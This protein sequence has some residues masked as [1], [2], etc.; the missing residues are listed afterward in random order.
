M[1]ERILRLIIKEFIQVLRDPRMKAMIFVLPIIQLLIF[2]YAVTTDVNNIKTIL[3]DSDKSVQSRQL[4]ESF[5]SS[6]LFTIVAYSEN[7]S[8]ITKSLDRG[9]AVI[10]VNIKKGFAEDILTGKQPVVQILIDGTNSNDGTLAMNYAQR[11][12]SDFGRDGQSK[13]LVNVQGRAW[14][15]PDLKSRNYNVPG[16]IAIIILM[17]SLLLTSMA[18]VREKEIGTMEQL[19]V[20]PMKP[21]E[22]ILGKS[23]PFAIICFVDVI[24]ISFA[25]MAWFKIPI[26]GSMVLLLFASTLFLMSCIGI[27]LLISTIS[28]TQ[29]EA[30][31]S[32]FFFYFPAV[33]LS[34]FM[35]PISNMPVPVQ[36]MTTINPLRYFLVIIRGIFLKG[37]G[38]AELWTQLV[39]LALLGTFFLLFSVSRFKKTVD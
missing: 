14:Y 28:K 12:I 37:T 10:G 9:R 27:G 29:Q 24:I 32:S 8:E 30:L 34:G 13:N 4:V 17:T 19:M 25:G 1:G 39:A 6:G 31:M 35:F 2:G 21:I 15:N 16:V 23:L 26:R 18:I 5:T 7:D 36:W 33:L 38:L 11:I 3:V 22:F 20:T